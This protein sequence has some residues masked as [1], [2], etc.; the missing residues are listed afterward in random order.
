MARAAAADQATMPEE[1][2]FGPVPAVIT[3]GGT[4][5]KQFITNTGEL[6][7]LFAQSFRLKGKGMNLKIASA[8]NQALSIIEAEDRKV[9]RRVP[10]LHP[11][12]R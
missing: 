12:R 7:K 5:W 8:L 3:G 11:P 1:D 4:E 6:N 2:M 9:R 10:L